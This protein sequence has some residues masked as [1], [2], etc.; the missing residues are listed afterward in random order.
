MADERNDQPKE[1][2]G[3][4]SC[5]AMCNSAWKPDFGLHGERRAS[6][7]RFFSQVLM[8]FL[9]GRSSQDNFDIS[10]TIVRPYDLATLPNTFVSDSG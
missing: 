3:Y 1:S 6:L 7:A 9:A 4:S 2:N 5:H 10:I 8:G